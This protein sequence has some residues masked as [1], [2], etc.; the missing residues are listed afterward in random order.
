MVK[1]SVDKELAQD[2]A[3]WL[4]I[5]NKD[6]ELACRLEPDSVVK[7]IKA[8]I[9]QNFYPADECLVICRKWELTEACAILCKNVG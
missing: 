7:K 1:Y 3:D 2:A 4:A 9:K 5:L 8:N 6:L